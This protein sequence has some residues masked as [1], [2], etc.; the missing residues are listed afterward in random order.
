MEPRFDLTPSS[1]ALDSSLH[2]TQQRLSLP[3]SASSRRKRITLRRT[4]AYKKSIKQRIRSDTKTPQR[5]YVISPQRTCQLS[6]IFPGVDGI[7]HI[8]HPKFEE[9]E[10]PDNL[11][12][13]GRSHE[14]HKSKPQ[15]QYTP[16]P[17]TAVFPSD[18]NNS[19]HGSSDHPPKTHSNVLRKRE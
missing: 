13:N 9:D 17:R 16:T 3:Q 19:R 10:P 4:H 11:A 2:S 6:C 12:P 1:P 14:E 5:W 8:P 15:K 18:T 7:A